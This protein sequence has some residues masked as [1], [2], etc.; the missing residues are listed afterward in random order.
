MRINGLT[1]DQGNNFDI[2]HVIT[3]AEV[4]FE[5]N[6]LTPVQLISLKYSN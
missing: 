1:V 6:K 5:V 2:H 3:I 4:I